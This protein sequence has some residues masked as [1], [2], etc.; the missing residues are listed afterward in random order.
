MVLVKGIHMNVKFMHA[1][2]VILEVKTFA[3]SEIVV[4]RNMLYDFI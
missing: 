2:I 1:P 3:D 4:F